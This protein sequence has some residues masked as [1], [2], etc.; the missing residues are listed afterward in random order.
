MSS[1]VGIPRATGGAQRRVNVGIVLLVWIAVIP[2]ALALEPDANPLTDERDGVTVNTPTAF[3]GYTLLAPMN[4]TSTYLIDL[5]GRIVN[6]WTS[7]F[8]PALSAYLL[9]NGHLLRP[10]VERRSGFGAPGAGGR[11]QEFNWEG[12]LVWDYSIGDSKLRPHHDIC[13]L[14][15]GN[16]LLIASDPKS[17]DEAVAAGRWPDSVE[18]Q[19]LPDCV[20]EVKPTGKTTGEIV[21]RWHAWDHLIQDR[22]ESLPNYGDVAAHPERIDVNFGSGMMD[23]LMQDPAELKALRA[24]GYVGG[25]DEDEELDEKGDEGAVWNGRGGP[26]PM[27]GDWMHVNSIAYNAKLDQIMLSVHEFNEVWIIDHSTSTTEAASSSGGRSGNGGDL[28]YRW[29][30]PQAYRGG[31]E[32]DQRLFGQHRAHW[33]DDGVPGAGHMLVFNNGL[34]RPDGGYSSVEEIVLPVDSRGA[35]T[36]HA[37]RPF[38]PE[39]AIWAYTAPEKSDFYSML[40]SGAQRLPNGNTLICSGNQALLFEVTRSGEIVWRYKHPGGGFGGPGVMPRPGELISRFILEAL[41]PT[42]AQQQSIKALQA[43][44]DAKLE[45]LLTANQRQRLSQATAL[46]R[47]GP[48][49]RNGPPDGRRRGGLPPA[50]EVL[51]ERLVEELAL[52][53]PQRGELEQIQQAVDDELAKIWTEDQQQQLKE[54]KSRPGRGMRPGFRP[55]FGPQA[56]RPGGPP[57]DAGVPGGPGRGPGGI[58]CS[59][60]YAIDHAAFEER[61]LTAG[62]NLAEAAARSAAT[63]AGR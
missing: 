47:G 33:L 18:S 1:R 57:P 11:I 22:D 17:K 32:G 39:R 26:G 54:M 20:L 61:E 38:A 24:L 25:G 51:S 2:Q 12:E 43:D 19:L 21:W 15:N 45:Q 5:E 56:G 23:R 16:V 48:P 3:K 49:Q 27:Q 37:G 7:E 4:S 55:P 13:R 29:G 42:D 41:E 59:H 63:E 52:S 58:F 36:Y 6:E 46:A 28:L 44:V 31:S 40:I 35:Y 30:N 8:T 14:P 60:R 53:D 62:A 9:E 10:G 34:G 50:G